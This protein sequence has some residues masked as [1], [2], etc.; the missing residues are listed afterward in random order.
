MIIRRN[1]LVRMVYGSSRPE[2]SA[3]LMIAGRGE[4]LQPSEPGL[5]FSLVNINWQ[6]EVLEEVSSVAH[7]V[8]GLIHG[9]KQV[10]DDNG[11]VDPPSVFDVSRSARL[12][13]RFP[14]SYH[15]AVIQALNPACYK[16]STPNQ[17]EAHQE[18]PWRE[19]LT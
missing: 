7:P 4:I 12:R 14:S 6:V 9:I 10:N 19:L 5:D 3:L 11:N 2:V 13:F 17:R 18:L 1:C 8:V 15:D 16:L